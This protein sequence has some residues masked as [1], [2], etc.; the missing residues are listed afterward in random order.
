QPPADGGTP[1]K[2][3][4][5][6]WCPDGN[7]SNGSACPS[8]YAPRADRGRAPAGPATPTPARVGYSIPVPARPPA[9][10]EA[11]SHR[12]FRLRAPLR[13][14]QGGGVGRLGQMR[15]HADLAHLLGHVPPPGTRL[16]SEGHRRVPVEA[17]QQSARCS[18]SAGAI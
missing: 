13:P 3:R 17:G 11:A 10:P 1:P 7:G 15:L 18:R 8:G 16:Q 2:P 6:P 5:A 4:P 14:A 12:P 9:A